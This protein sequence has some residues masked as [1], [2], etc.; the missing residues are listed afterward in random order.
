LEKEGSNAITSHI[1]PSLI[2][3]CTDAQISP[4]IS[5]HIFDPIQSHVF[6][7]L[8]KIMKEKMKASMTK[9]SYYR[10]LIAFFLFG[11]VNNFAYVVFLSAATD[12]LDTF[13]LATGNFWF[14]F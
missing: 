11:V 8:S 12:I 5:P 14:G 3:D 1:P 7:L 6:S 4:N 2:S 10:S 13:N 9:G